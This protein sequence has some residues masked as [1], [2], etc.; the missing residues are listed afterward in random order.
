[1]LEA[2]AHPV[3]TRIYTEIYIPCVFSGYINDYEIILLESVLIT[4]KKYMLVSLSIMLFSYNVDITYFKKC[5][6]KENKDR[7]VLPFY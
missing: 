2:Y 1:V 4:L 3:L 5:K 7:I 6:N